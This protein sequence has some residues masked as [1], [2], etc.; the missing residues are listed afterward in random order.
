M[1]FSLF[2]LSCA[3]CRYFASVGKLCCA[4][5]VAALLALLLAM[6][7]TELVTVVTASP[8][9]LAVLCSPDECSGA[10]K[11]GETAVVA[12]SGTLLLGGK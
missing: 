3:F 9:E 5:C 11:R 8:V 4:E 7:A 10:S 6:S 12:E 2:S 1:P